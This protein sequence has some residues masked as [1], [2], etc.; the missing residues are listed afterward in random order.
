MDDLLYVTTPFRADESYTSDNDQHSE[1][2]DWTDACD[3]A[4]AFLDLHS[5]WGYVMVELT[6]VKLPIGAH[7]AN[8]RRPAMMLDRRGRSLPPLYI[9]PRHAHDKKMR[10]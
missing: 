3:M 5:Q 4:A 6:S 9:P 8:S 10:V 1:S 7:D 2:E